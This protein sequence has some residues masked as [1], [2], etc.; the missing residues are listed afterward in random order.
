MCLVFGGRFVD[1]EQGVGEHGDA[2]VGQGADQELGERAKPS[3]RDV[4]AQQHAER[5]PAA[6]RQR[7]YQRD[8][9]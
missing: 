4:P 3:A 7:T 9:D 1:N 6:R 2:A 5:A 8:V